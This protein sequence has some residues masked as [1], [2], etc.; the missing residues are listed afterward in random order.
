MKKIFQVPFTLPVISASQLPEYLNSIAANG[1][2]EH[3]QGRDFERNV[4]PHFRILQAQDSVNL[5]E[6]KRLINTFSR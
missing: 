6:I 4:R 1:G 3:A 5:R 2:F